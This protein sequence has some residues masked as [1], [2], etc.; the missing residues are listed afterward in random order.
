MEKQAALTLAVE[1]GTVPSR[2]SAAARK[3]AQNLPGIVVHFEHK[4][5]K[6][7]RNPVLPH[8]NQEI[9]PHDNE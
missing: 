9:H 3:I 4:C 7:F 5:V 2:R 6:S 1:D 8:L